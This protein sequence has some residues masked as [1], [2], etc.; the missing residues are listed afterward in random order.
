MKAKLLERQIEGVYRGY[1]RNMLDTTI[2]MGIC[3]SS[4]QIVLHPIIP[5]HNIVVKIEKRIRY[6]FML[7]SNVLNGDCL[8]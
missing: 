5:N 8:T 2:I 7:F 6:S 4:Q 1:S 3:Y